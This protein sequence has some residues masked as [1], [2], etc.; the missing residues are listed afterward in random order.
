MK[1][2]S[3]GGD[4]GSPIGQVGRPDDEPCVC[5][6]DFTCLADHAESN[7]YYDED[8]DVAAA[9]EDIERHRAE[10]EAIVRALA[11]MAA[12]LDWEWNGLCVLCKSPRRD[13]NEPSDHEPECP[14]RRAKEW[15]NDG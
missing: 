10:P 2:P 15:V 4:G 5:G 11:A 8:P 6:T 12:P 3:T 9:F 14:W 13:A 7:P 1:I